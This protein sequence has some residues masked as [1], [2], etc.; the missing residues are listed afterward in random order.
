M[1]FTVRRA[2]RQYTW[3]GTMTSIR[4]ILL[5]M[6]DEVYGRETIAVTT[7]IHEISKRITWPGTVFELEQ[8]YAEEP[9]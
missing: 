8:E 7:S 4:A 3:D 1:T 6:L 2:Y 5:A 9:W